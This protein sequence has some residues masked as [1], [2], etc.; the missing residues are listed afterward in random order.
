[1][2][3]SFETLVLSVLGNLYQFI[4]VKRNGLNNLQSDSSRVRLGQLQYVQV[5]ISLQARLQIA[6][7]VRLILSL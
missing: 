6:Q 1:M 2:N 4:H 5:N 7:D 3:Q